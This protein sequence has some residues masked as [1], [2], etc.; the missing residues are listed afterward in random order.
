MSDTMQVIFTSWPSLII[1]FTGTVLEFV[2]M[3]VPVVDEITDT[4]LT[5]VIPVIATLASMGT[6]GLHTAA[7]TGSGGYA[8]A[9]GDDYYGNANDGN[10]YYDDGNAYNDGNAYDDNGRQLGAVD[11]A[12]TFFHF[13]II[14]GGIGLA[15]CMHLIKMLVRLVGEGWLTNILTVLET[16]WTVTTV[17]IAV[18]FKPF[19]I[20]FA[21]IL[22]I[23]SGWFIKKRCSKKEQESKG[24]WCLR[25]RKN[26]PPVA[27]EQVQQGE[28]QE[29]T[30]PSPTKKKRSFLG[31]F[32]KKKKD[33]TTAADSNS[34]VEEDN[35]NPGWSYFSMA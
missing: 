11:S 8:S 15:L 28:Q 27:P 1:M 3:C 12:W 22:L 35:A 7:E 17:M 6:L 14:G 29:E 31:M 26:K 10:A 16:I 5:F 24:R 20:L 33:S 13:V 25:G 30:L 34:E 19:A 4:A 2:A 9:Y 32:R 23:A 21:G 18:F